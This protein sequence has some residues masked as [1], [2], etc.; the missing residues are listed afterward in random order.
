MSGPFDGAIG[1]RTPTVRTAVKPELRDL[2]IDRR[3]SEIPPPRPRVFTR[4][5][6]PIVLLAAAFGAVAYAAR[7]VLLPASVVRVE[8]VVQGTANAEVQIDVTAPGWIAPDAFATQV[9]ALTDGVVDEV[10]A[11]DGQQVAAGEVVATL[12]A[13]DAEIALARA[14]AAHTRARAELAAVDAERA[15]VQP[16]VAAA[17]AGVAATRAELELKEP[18]ADGRTISRAEIARLRAQLREDEAE[19]AAANA[20][21]ATLDARSAFARAAIDIAAADVREAELRLDRCQVRAPTA[22]VVLRRHASPGTVIGSGSRDSRVVLELYDPSRLMVRTD[23]PFADAARI[24]VG[25]RA[26]VTVEALPDAVFEGRVVRVVPEAD[27]AKNAVAFHVA[28]DAPV[29]GLRPEMI[30][31]VRFAAATREPDGAAAEPATFVPAAAV[32]DGRVFV[33]VDRDGDVARAAARTVETVGERDGHLQV[34]G[35]LQAG[36]RVVVAG[37][38]D[39]ADGDRVRIADPEA[40]R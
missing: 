11:L 40:Q 17:E 2:S 36:D 32:R 13:T 31:R 5:V 18:L 1:T 10:L 35:G 8:P 14:R 21:P 19:L 26:L 25:R 29:P 28:L 34:R 24:D 20:R 39:L 33:L 30:A 38:A 7:D 4:L 37:P 22:G 12:I 16:A 23:V 6:L 27:A 15:A 9:T 3:P